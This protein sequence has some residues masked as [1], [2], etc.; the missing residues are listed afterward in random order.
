[1]N[2]REF[3]GLL[4]GG[5]AMV[6]A[7]G[8]GGAA[9]RKRGVKGERPNIILIMADDLGYNELG[10]FGMRWPEAGC[11]LRIITRTGRC[12]VR[13]GRRFLRGGISSGAE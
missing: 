11:G 5:A 12:A 8:C 2:R 4:A 13:R 9:V 1:M 7:P 6:L 3:V 10:C